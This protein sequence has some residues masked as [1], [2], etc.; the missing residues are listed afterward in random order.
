MD[1]SHTA[2]TAVS[3]D[4]SSTPRLLLTLPY[5]P[6]S[7]PLVKMGSNDRLGLTKDS[8]RDAQRRDFTEPENSFYN[9]NVA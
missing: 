2:C 1:P 3:V 5:L 4:S 8:I 9:A 6:P 7:P